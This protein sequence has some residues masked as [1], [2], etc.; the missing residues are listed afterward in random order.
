MQIELA[1]ELVAK[2]CAMTESGMDV[3]SHE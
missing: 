1:K 3:E 2:C